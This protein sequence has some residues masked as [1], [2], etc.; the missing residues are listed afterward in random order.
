MLTTV[1]GACTN[2]WMWINKRISTSSH[3][4]VRCN[5]PDITAVKIWTTN[6]QILLFSVY[7]PPVDLH[8]DSEEVPV[9]PTL[10]EIQSTIQ[11]ATQAH[12]AWGNNRVHHVFVGHAVELINFFH[13]WKLQRC[14]PRRT[15]TFWSLSHPGKTSTIDLTVTDSP[16]KLVKCHLYHNHYG[17]DPSSDQQ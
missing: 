6:V 10:D 8:Q 17:S 11:Q 3:R 4:Q 1:S 15:P 13:T 14:L 7:I 2:Q 9:Q 12:P 5:H 16:E